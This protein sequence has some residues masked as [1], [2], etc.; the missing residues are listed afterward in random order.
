MYRSA[1]GGDS[2]DATSLPAQRVQTLAAAAAPSGRIYAGAGMDV[3]VSE[4]DGASWTLAS[5]L[6]STAKALAVHPITPALVYAGTRLD[7][8]RATTAGGTG[9]RTTSGCHPTR[10]SRCWPSTRSR[11]RSSTSACVAGAGVP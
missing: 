3:Y 10:G 5:T 8:V 11:P 9:R 6:S 7:G 2:W 1:D 4:G